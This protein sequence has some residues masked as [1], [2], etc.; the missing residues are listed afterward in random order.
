MALGVQKIKIPI[1]QEEL[2]IE[3]ITP[4]LQT[5]LSQFNSNSVKITKDYNQYLGQHS[6][7]SKTRTYDSDTKINNI[8]SEPHLLAMV[9]F[10][11]GYMLG[12]P[13]E[14]ALNTSENDIEIETLHRVFKDCDLRTV[15][16]DVAQ[17]LYATGVGYYFIQPKKELPK[18]ADESPFEVFCQPANTCCK[19]YSSYIGEKPLFDCIFTEVT[20]QTKAN[21]SQKFTIID[22]YFPNA[23]YEFEVLNNSVP[24]QQNLVRVEDRPLYHFLPLVEQYANRD[25]LGIVSVGETLQYAIDKITSNEL[26]NI[27]E[28]VNQL[29]VF[30]NVMLGKDNAEKLANFI[31]MK[32]N[33]VAEIMPNNPQFPADLKTLA[34]NLDHKNIMTLKEE[35]TQVLY[36]T[37]GVPLASS[38]VTSGGDTQG[39]RQLGNGWENAYTVIL[40]EINSLSKADRELLKIMLWIC[41][42]SPYTAINN[43]T[44]SDIEIKYNINRSNNLLTKTQ[45][46]VNLVQNEKAP[47]PAKIAMQICELTSDPEAVGRAIEEYKQKLA[48]E[49]QMQEQQATET[50]VGIQ[51]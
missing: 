13:K 36:D 23:F 48:N 17:W 35:L 39:A 30:V 2:T 20:K 12:I 15:C 22:I 45:S 47:V 8:V 4:Y 27:D 3:A 25:R 18:N 40:K 6:I 46:Y 42:Q 43:L 5:I 9:N 37:S 44:A 11:V 29:Y 1:K 7:L 19:V 49:T 33:G 38:S 24:K 21:L 16:D 41:K 51:E 32:K 34:T 14:Y 50:I 28:V 26:D 31:A 10:K